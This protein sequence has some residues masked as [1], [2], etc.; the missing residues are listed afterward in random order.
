MSILKKC[1]KVLS[2]CIHKNGKEIYESD[3]IIDGE[4]TFLEKHVSKRHSSNFNENLINIELQKQKAFD[5]NYNN[6]QHFSSKTILK[7]TSNTRGLKLPLL[8]KKKTTQDDNNNI[9]YNELYTDHLKHKA[10]IGHDNPEVYSQIADY[11]Y[12]PLIDSKQ[13]KLDNDANKTDDQKSLTGMRDIETFSTQVEAFEWYLKLLFDTMTKSI[14]DDKSLVDSDRAKRLNIAN[15]HALYAHNFYQM[16]TTCVV[17]QHQ[18]K[19]Q[20][21]RVHPCL[22]VLACLLD[23]DAIRIVESHKCECDS[24]VYLFSTRF[25]F[26]AWKCRFYIILKRPNRSSIDRLT[27]IQ[28]LTSCHKLLQDKS[29]KV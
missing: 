29:T 27:L 17:N 16:K 24:Y 22:I 21:A 6:L 5:D 10:D 11:D 9:L 2:G 3:P 18:I 19:L 4:F 28:D 23:S 13:N 7:D 14:H 12:E 25:K 26:C 1:K 15:A 8:G 20:L